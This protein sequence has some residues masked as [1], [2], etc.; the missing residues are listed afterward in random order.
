MFHKLSLTKGWY[1]TFGRVEVVE[2]VEMVEIV[3]MVTR[4]LSKGTHF[5]GRHQD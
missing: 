5:I 3:E 4:N 1:A 2:L